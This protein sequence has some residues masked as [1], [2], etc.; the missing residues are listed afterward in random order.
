[1]IAFRGEPLDLLVALGEAFEKI[2]G[3]ESALGLDREEC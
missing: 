3:Q 1:V 2:G